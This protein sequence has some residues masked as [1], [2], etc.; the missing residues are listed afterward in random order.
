MNQLIPKDV[1]A[2]LKLVER[3]TM[4]MRDGQRP[5]QSVHEGYAYM[6]DFV[7]DFFAAVKAHPRNWTKLRVEAVNVAALA[8]RFVVDITGVDDERKSG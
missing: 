3:Q 5:L 2:A 4:A 7:D 1:T 6:V 8:V